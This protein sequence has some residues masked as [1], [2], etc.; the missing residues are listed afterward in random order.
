[1]EIDSFEEEFDHS[2]CLDHLPGITEFYNICHSDENGRFISKCPGSGQGA[3]LSG[4]VDKAIQDTDGLSGKLTV[5]E[6]RGPRQGSLADPHEGTKEVD[7]VRGYDPK[8]NKPVPGTDAWLEAHG[9]S[10]EVFEQR[11]YVRFEADQ[12][13]PAIVEAY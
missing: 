3:N 11:P 6:E 13:D 1:M 8:T 7:G 4:R 9:I 5:P 2:L 10:R 12:T